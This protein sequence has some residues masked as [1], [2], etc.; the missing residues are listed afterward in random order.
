MSS[1]V[2]LYRAVLLVVLTTLPGISAAQT[3]QMVYR[4]KPPYSYV[5]N[6]IAKG[7]LLD[8]TRRILK[9]AGLDAEFRE[10]PPKRIFLEIEKNEYPVCSFGWYRLAER[11][12]YAKYSE[13]IHQDRPHVVV[14]GPH[15]I[16]KVRR[17][18]SLKTLM[19][20]RSL[21]LAALDGVSYGLELDRIISSFPG[22][23]D[24]SLQSPLNVLR[25]IS[26]QHGDFMFLDQEDFDY[27]TESSADFRAG[28]FQRIEYPDM[29]PGLK[30]YIL[31]SQKVG[32]D[33]MRRI[34]AAIDL[35]RG[36]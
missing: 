17:H 14:A 20:D 31:C 8:R 24:R 5:E 11:E 2:W 21:L 6:G 29:P 7:F 34:N 12:R 4:D 15:S 1:V 26:A 3:L 10:M 33:V 35:E 36:R 23:V 30:R 25:K 13:P 19:N 22:A 28:H 27:L 32:S 16:D 18:S 9:R